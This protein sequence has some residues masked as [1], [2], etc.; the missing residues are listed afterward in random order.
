MRW[1]GLCLAGLSLAVVPDRDFLYLWA[2]RHKDFAPRVGRVLVREYSK[3]SYPIS[4]EVYEI[5]NQGIQ[6]IGEFPT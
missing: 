6:A 3:A 2:A 4:T 1:S 5:T